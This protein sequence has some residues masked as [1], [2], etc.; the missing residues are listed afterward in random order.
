MEHD[1]LQNKGRH[2]LAEQNWLV[3]HVTPHFPQLCGSSSVVTHL[4]PQ[5]AC[6]TVQLHPPPSSP[7]CPGWVVAP[8]PTAQTPRTKNRSTLLMGVTLPYG[9]R[10][11]GRTM[12]FAGSE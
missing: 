6:P 8:Q 3:E 2:A 10:K 7:I 4:P 1:R 11:L 5:Q 9:I 12:P